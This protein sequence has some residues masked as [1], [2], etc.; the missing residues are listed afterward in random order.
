MRQ[1]EYFILISARTW[2]RGYP[3]RNGYCG[4]G[5][6]SY[7]EWIHVRDGKIA[8]RT[9]G[10]FES[11]FDS[12]YGGITGWRGTILTAKTTD[13]VEKRDGPADVPARVRDITFTFDA[14]HPDEGIKQKEAE[15]KTP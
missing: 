6:E 8:E 10:L 5:V 2:S 11:C 3:P 1:S 4:R 7:I 12:R 15:H 13:I 14:A 9:K